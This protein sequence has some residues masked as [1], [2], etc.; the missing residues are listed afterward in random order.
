MLLR[1]VPL[2]LILMHQMSFI[3]CV[4]CGKPSCDKAFHET[5]G[6]FMKGGFRHKTN[7]SGLEKD[8]PKMIWSLVCG[9]PLIPQPRVKSFLI[10]PWLVCSSCQYI[11]KHQY[12]ALWEKTSHLFC[13]FAFNQKQSDSSRFSEKPVKTLK[14]HDISIVLLNQCQSENLNASAFS[15][16]QAN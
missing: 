16:L 14:I 2:H 5:G 10:L 3:V 8:Y 9:P 6:C 7:R 1:H 13:P 12:L 15:S 4:R 11:I